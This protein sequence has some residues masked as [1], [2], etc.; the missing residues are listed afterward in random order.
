MQYKSLIALLPLLGSAISTPIDAR[1]SPSVDAA[2]Q[3][4]SY[5]IMALRSASPVH[6]LR[7]NAI[8]GRLYLGGA[9]KQF[10]RDRVRYPPSLHNILLVK[11]SGILMMV[12][13]G[14]TLVRSGP[15]IRIT[16]L[17]TLEQVRTR[18]SMRLLRQRLEQ[19]D[20][21][22]VRLLKMGRGRY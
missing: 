16:V 14:M 21:W 11:L 17:G 9:T 6:F 8:A 12:L 7:V 18:H 3:N 4:L 20:L 19:M 1:Q 15:P 5:T 13:L 10:L 2:L 22:R